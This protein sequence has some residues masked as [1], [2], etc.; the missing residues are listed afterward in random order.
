MVTALLAVYF[1]NDQSWT[2]SH[3][4]TEKKLRAWIMDVDPEDDYEEVLRLRLKNSEGP[5]TVIMDSIAPAPSSAITISAPSL[6]LSASLLLLLSGMGVFLAFIWTW[7]VDKDGGTSS[8][9]DVFIVYIVTLGISLATVGYFSLGR[10]V[11]PIRQTIL[12]S[13]RGLQIDA[14]VEG[15]TNRVNRK[16]VILIRQLL[17][18]Y[19]TRELMERQGARLEE[20]I[21]QLQ[22]AVLSK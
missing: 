12:K 9:R 2:I 14:R 20:R 13:I 17:S 6:L 3:L 10:L 22:Q 11:V 21:V 8:S 4:S 19:D 1:S 16:E 5:S 18:A 7:E 15:L